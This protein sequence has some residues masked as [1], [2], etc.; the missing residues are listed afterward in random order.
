MKKD[1]AVAIFCLAAWLG[2]MLL[3]HVI[4]AGE[5]SAHAYGLISAWWSLLYCSLLFGATWRAIAIFIVLLTIAV[6]ID[7]VVGLN[8][9]F[10]DYPI[11]FSLHMLE[12][13][14][15]FLA[16]WTSPFVI[17]V[18]VRALRRRLIRMQGD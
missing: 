4:F 12:A 13:S 3:T 15:L 2:V 6:V 1:G 7:S 17:N 9:L 8:F 16:F 18:L 5:P 11:G 14:G 10:H